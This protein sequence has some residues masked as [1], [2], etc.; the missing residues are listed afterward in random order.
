[1]L[2]LIIWCTSE[3][4]ISYRTEN[5]RLSAKC[6]ALNSK[7]ESSMKYCQELSLKLQERIQAKLED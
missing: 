6:D 2:K 7:L 1:M 5:T 3:N 4:A